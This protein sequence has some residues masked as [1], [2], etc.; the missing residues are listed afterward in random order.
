MSRLMSVD[1]E[2]WIRILSFAPIFVCSVVGFGLA[3]WKWH[4]LREPNLPAN[5]AL[6][7]LRQLV[8]ARDLE[9]AMAL[10][11]NDRS[12]T[13]R[14]IRPLLALA[15]HA[16]ARLTARAGQVGAQL[17]RELEHGLGALGLIATLGPL[18]GLL[19][20]VVGITVVFNRLA[21]T[22]GLASPQQLAGGI[23]T[24]LHT[25]IA[26]LIVGV[27][28]LVSHRY[29]AAWVDRL[30]GQIE[31]IGAEMVDLLGRHEDGG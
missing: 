7:R 17:V 20:T 2:T 8:K 5:V 11:G 24:A 10:V 28:A 9:G 22:G 18:F 4:Q 31:T 6:A 26:G 13:V 1:L 21:S 15:G 19:G 27:L 12:R 16:T 25:T 23:G 30:V 14:L 3:L 29:L